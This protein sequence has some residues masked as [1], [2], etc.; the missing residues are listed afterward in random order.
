MSRAER[1]EDEKRRIIESCFSKL[2][3]NGQLAESY[4]T[5]IRIQEDGSSPSA[6]PPP[7]SPP[8]H[9]KPR[10]IIIA[11]RSTGRVRMHKARE[12]NNGSFSIGKTWNM[13]ELSCI[14]SFAN[15]PHPPQSEREANHRA[16]AG[17]VGFVVTISKPY[18]WQAGTSKEKDFFIASAVK[19]YRKYTK[20]QTPE[21]RG[22]D[23]KERAQI[24][25]AF[26]PTAPSSAPSQSGQQ[27]ARTTGD[28]SVPQ[29]PQPPF[30][31]R[32]QSRDGSRY[33]GSPGPP[34]SV[35]DGGRP[36]SGPSSRRPSDSPARFGPGP[37]APGGPRAFASTEQIRQPSR[38]GRPELRPGTSPGPGHRQPMLGQQNA[39][40]GEQP[41]PSPGFPPTQPEQLPSRPKSP[42]QRSLQQSIDGASEDRKLSDTPS[43]DATK[44]EG[45]SLFQAA[46]DRY[47]N[48]QSQTPEQTSKASSPRRLP[49]L[50]TKPSTPAQNGSAKAPSDP[51]LPT[52]VSEDS[53]GIDLGDAAAVGALTSY[54]GPGHSS[55]AAPATALD[56]A[57]SPTTP[58]RSNR[59]PAAEISN[60]MEL[61]PAPLQAR[62]TQ[63]SN[64]SHVD[65]STPRGNLVE[66]TPEVKPLHVGKSEMDRSLTGS[67]PSMMPSP[68]QPAPGADQLDSPDG[69][70]DEEQY[71]PGLGPMFKKRAIADRFKK[72]A[73]AAGAFK[74]R[75]GGAAERILKA[76]SE[77][78]GE[79]DGITGVV[80]RPQ[81]RG[82][83][84][85]RPSTPVNGISDESASRETPPR[86][87]ISSPKSPPHIEH[88][89][90]EDIQRVAESSERPANQPIQPVETEDEA[91]NPTIEQRQ[92]RQPQVKIKRRS[93]HQERYLAA[94]GVDRSLLEDKGLDFEM[95]LTEFGWNNDILRPKQLNNLE[96][97]IRRE[98]GR[99]EAGAWLSHADAAREERVNLVE[100]LLDKAIAECD[101][102]EGLLTLYHVELSSLNDDIAYIEAQS[103]GLQVQSANQKLLQS[104]L[105]TL[106][107]T[108]SLDRRVMEPLRYGDLGDSTGLEE[109]EFSLVKLYQALLTM[110]PKLRSN[111]QSLPTAQAAV[112]DHETADMVALQ[113]KKV[114]YDRE[115]AEFCQR[116]MQFLDSRF[117]TSMNSIKGRALRVGGGGGL[118]KLH[119]EVFGEVRSALWMYSPILLFTK[120]LNPPAWSTLL[121][122]YQQRAGPV[123]RD[124]F[125]ENLQNWKRAARTS[126]GDEV[127][128]L[129]TSLEKEDPTAGGL[130]STAR[131]LTVKRSQTLAKT[132]RS[133]T[134]DKHTTSEHKQPGAIMRAQA[135][136]GAV[137]EMAPLINREQNF[138]VDF[139]H[140]SSM[141]SM[142]FIDAVQSSPPAA[143]LGTNLLERKPVEPNREAAG[144]VTSAMLKIFDFFL[145]ETKAMQDWAVADDPVQ[146]VGVLATLCRHAYYLQDSNQD[147]LLQL[148]DN[149]AESLRTRLSRFVDEQI[150]AIEDTKVKIK[151]RKGV[152]AFMKIFPHFSAAVENTFSAVAGPDYD[153]PA[154]CVAEVRKI[155][156]EAYEKLNRTMFDSL[157]VI[158][159]ESPVAGNT[160]SKQAHTGTDDPEDKEMLNYH[161]LLIEN[162]NHYV[163]EVDDGGR[164]GVLAEWKGR[165]LT[166][167]AEALEAYV[168]RVIRRPL[169]KLLDYL[170]SAESILATQQ[171][172]ATALSTRPSYS[173]KAMR[174]LLSAHDSK[175]VRRGIDTLRKRIDKHFG[176][177]DEEQLSRGLVTFVCKECERNYESVLE[178]LERLVED[179]YPRTEGE[180]D[181][182]VDFT[183]ADIQA[184][185]R[186]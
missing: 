150:R 66:S 49:Q 154:P 57:P 34:P 167:R 151:K 113:E 38:D 104:E 32:E 99:V 125:R 7:D 147:Y 94:L 85:E 88:E 143:R 31:Q 90:A 86:V 28:G 3:P 169:G 52:A 162:M 89:P 136:A 175:E 5:H 47:M 144:L 64:G 100:S 184:G 17:S 152:I 139:F 93:A 119:S 53:N 87:E 71:R 45:A 103:Q 75:P 159:K 76:K 102:L 14:E 25:G 114:I 164:D 68:L 24:L 141:E 23:D 43:T 83:P 26:P 27:S 95:M 179:V 72:A 178:R 8:E 12:N 123:Y 36:G 63:E 82:K 35:S 98:Q 78:D 153:G 165:A 158:A 177:A 9:K 80:P 21:L 155:I 145:A 96:A 55:A 129:F 84:D 171:G 105:Q 116:L 149:L 115:T 172:S 138:I 176:E 59:R 124:T 160:A 108:M 110:D 39:R 46:R 44:R 42:A 128:I 122:M 58:E 174:T 156:D 126:T 40:K 185:F 6:P 4:I 168:S 111:T 41:P 132:F 186:R 91:S 120:Q 106:V 121:R 107:D 54:W 109:I 48:Y 133:A 74:P 118:A 56:A 51:Q 170:E 163:E 180:K 157:K 37:H 92:A 137:D 135:F 10:L 97:E 22:F 69:D 67:G 166:E 62:P 142:D 127:D 65:A 181:V 146:A 79:P 81:P 1:F 18:Y 16:W 73:N 29:P 20:G 19:I 112:G 77:R 11:V 33:R 50:D 2:D 131:K 15:P 13:E 183:K 61:R 117:M 161:I 101:E 130:T 134:G 140:L 70:M 173:R 30:A 60:S 148:L 182:V